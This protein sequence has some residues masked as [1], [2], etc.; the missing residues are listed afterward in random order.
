[1]FRVQAA[2]FGGW[3]SVQA[4]TGDIWQA[5]QATSAYRPEWKDLY[6]RS[7]KPPGIDRPLRTPHLRRGIEFL[8]KWKSLL[9][10]VVR[11]KK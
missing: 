11:K 9:M 5:V 1:M 7:G 10:Q 8:D 3:S 6:L 2:S 4:C